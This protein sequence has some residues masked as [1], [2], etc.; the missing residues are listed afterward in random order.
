M[1]HLHCIICYAPLQHHQQQQTKRQK[2]SFYFGR[3]TEEKDAGLQGQ[4]QI[5]FNLSEDKEKDKNDDNDCKY[6]NN[7]TISCK[8]VDTIEL[9]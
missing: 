6:F 3:G 1:K 2:I 5:K 7:K 9:E 4:G 8:V